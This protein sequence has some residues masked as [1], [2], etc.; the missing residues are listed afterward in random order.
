MLNKTTVL[1]ATL[2]SLL[3]SQNVFSD[4]ATLSVESFK[5][6]PQN[7]LP[8]TWMHAMNGNLSKPG[9]T[10]D[11]KSMKEAGIGGA[12]FFHV[13]RRNKPY[14]SRGPVRFGTESFF[15]HLVHAAA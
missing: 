5:K 15:D 13:H 4:N 8:K 2:Y 1:C 7:Y 3:I 6:P 10:D 11:F 14:S 9:F 12:I